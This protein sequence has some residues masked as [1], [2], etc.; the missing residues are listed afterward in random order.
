MN[1]RSSTFIT[2]T[3]VV[4]FAGAVWAWHEVY[5]IFPRV[6]QA[7]EIVLAALLIDQAARLFPRKPR[8]RDFGCLLVKYETATASS[9]MLIAAAGMILA[10]ALSGCDCRATSSAQNFCTKTNGQIQ[11]GPSA[12][13]FPES[14]RRVAFVRFAVMTIWRKLE[15]Q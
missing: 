2:A 4:L 8:T 10:I 12:P 5:F 3:G 6:G 13:C 15:R 1:L 9:I 7:A 14:L 11:E